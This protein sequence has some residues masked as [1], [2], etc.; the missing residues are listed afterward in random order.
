M[1]VLKN[2]RYEIY[3]QAVF[4]GK[5]GKDAAIIAGYSPKTADKK[6]PNL[7]KLVVISSRIKELHEKAAEK[8]LNSRVMSIQERKERLTEIAK[9]KNR[10]KLDPIK[11]IA[12]LNKMEGSYEP[13][14]HAIDVQADV[15]FIIGKGYASKEDIKSISDLKE[16]EGIKPIVIPVE[17]N[18]AVE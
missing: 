1:P 12:E 5:S 14:R 3:A 15:F 18:N 10:M 17:D 8:L 11:A 16:L 7:S 2:S 4:S 6:A 13:E 9:K